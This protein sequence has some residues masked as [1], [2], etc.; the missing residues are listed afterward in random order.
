MEQGAD[1]NSI[2]WIYIYHAIKISIKYSNYI[3]DL[4]NSFS[5]ARIVKR[6]VILISKVLLVFL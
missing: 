4:F 2:G 5:N 1:V 6:G 3:T